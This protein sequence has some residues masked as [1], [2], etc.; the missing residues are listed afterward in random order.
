MSAKVEEEVEMEERGGGGQEEPSPPDPEPHPPDE[1]QG[2]KWIFFTHKNIMRPLRYW[3][4]QEYLDGNFF[5]GKPA[6]I[7]SL[8]LVCCQKESFIRLL[9]SLLDSIGSFR[10]EELLLFFQEPSIKMLD[11]FLSWGEVAWLQYNL[12]IYFFV[13]Q[14]ATV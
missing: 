3:P 14:T 13:V 10:R 7:L 12:P 5:L 1:S 6:Y 2:K 8:R 11:S 4:L 9:S